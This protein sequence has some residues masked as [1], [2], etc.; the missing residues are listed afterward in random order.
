MPPTGSPMNARRIVR[1]LLLL[2]LMVAGT[3]GGVMLYQRTIQAGDGGR[4]P[5]GTPLPE[6]DLQRLDGGENWRRDQLQGRPAVLQY[7]ATY[8]GV[9]RRELPEMQTLHEDAHGR[10]EVLTVT[11]ESPERVMGFLEAQGLDL[12]VLIDHAGDFRQWLGLE[13]LPTTVII[14]DQGRVVHDFEGAAFV[15]LLQRRLLGLSGADG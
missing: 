9:C 5:V 12:P 11:S 4:I 6:M 3:Y 13:V 10:Y 1:E 14:D 7:W 2:T 8:C 15:D